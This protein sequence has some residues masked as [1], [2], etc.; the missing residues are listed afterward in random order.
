MLALAPGS[1]LDGIEDIRE[2]T[3]KVDWEKGTGSV[4]VAFQLDGQTYSWAMDMQYD[5]IDGGY[6]GCAEQYSG[7]DGYPGAFF[8]S[9]GITVRERLFFTVPR[10]GRAN[11]G[12]PQACLWINLLQNSNI[13]APLRPLSLSFRPGTSFSLLPAPAM[14]R[15]L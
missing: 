11:S 2:D 3:D 8:M 9:R 1:P 14:Q 12:R 4:N 15:I 6:P 7:T 10:N 5:W 13:S